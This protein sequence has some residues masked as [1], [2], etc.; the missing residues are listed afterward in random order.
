[1]SL[2]SWVEGKRTYTAALIAA[3]V[4]ANGVLH[5]VDA[6]TQNALLG[7]ALALGLYGLRAAVGQVPEQS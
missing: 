6:D 7:L 1:M 3:L 4:A 5:W 2:F